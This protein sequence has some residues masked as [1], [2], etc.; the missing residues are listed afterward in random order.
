MRTV[1]R[2]LIADD[3]NTIVQLVR[4][5]LE[6]RG[7]EVIAA[8]DGFEA[9]EKVFF[10]KPDLV[11]LDVVMPKMD[12]YQLCQFF[13]QE[14]GLSM[15]PIV[16]L[17]SKTSSFDRFWGLKAGANDYFEKPFEPYKLVETVEK[18]LT[19]HDGTIIEP[20]KSIFGKKLNVLLEKISS[21]RDDPANLRVR[22][23]DMA[24]M[25]LSRINALMD[26][27]LM[28]LTLIK[29]ISGLISSTGNINK[30]VRDLL[31]KLSLLLDYS[32]AILFL[33]DK[34][35]SQMIIQCK[36]SISEKFLRSC[37][38]LVLDECRTKGIYNSSDNLS[39]KIVEMSEFNVSSHEEEV[40]SKMASP[41]V[42]RGIQIGELFL[43]SKYDMQMTEEKVDMLDLFTSQISLL[44]DNVTMVEKLKAYGDQK[45]Q[46]LSTIYEI[47]RLMSSSFDMINL[48]NMVID[49]V[50]Y[51]MNVK[52][53]SMMLIDEETEEIKVKLARGMNK[54]VVE[55]MRQK[56]NKESISGWV[57]VNK[58]PLLVEDI[59]DDDRFATNMRKS[60]TS[61]SFI[62]VPI[63]SRGVIKGVLNIT[64][65]ESGENFNI[66]DLEM[67]T[68][69]A[70]QIAQAIENAN[71]YKQ[72]AE[73]ERM[74]RELEIARN[75]QMS[76][77]PQESPHIEELDVYGKC[78]PAKE[79]SGDYFDYLGL[80]EEHFSFVIGDV[81]GKGVPAALTV[82]MI[83]SGLRTEVVNNSYPSHLLTKLNSVIIEDIDPDMF[84]TLFF[85]RF[86]RKTRELEY[87]NGGHEFPLLYRAE[88]DELEYIKKSGL[89]V[90]MF[91]NAKYSCHKKMINPGDVILFYT[92]GVVDVLNKD[93][94][95]FG[96]EKFRN[97]FLKYVRQSSKN[98]VEN[99]IKEIMEFKGNESQFDDIT[100]LCFSLKS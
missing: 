79:M 47:G 51:V 95:K 36:S 59:R 60:Y 18:L 24:I 52:K 11:I 68:L 8:S 27:R 28:E 99:I 23:N 67:M 50:I 33:R 45:S 62:C 34:N 98:I 58:K 29:E 72:L 41:L 70:G 66:D 92:D 54:Q 55:T 4:M 26:K 17:T 65:K 74:D 56:V 37:R 93:K 31:A 3:S 39:V 97:L 32:V 76:W 90:G 6:Q 49:N 14:E 9:I 91:H 64:D 7:F 96:M 19:E 88:T 71:L 42:I 53:C 1:K 21:L 82:I 38:G 30:F 80:N 94:E 86:N 12:G 20:T 15:L 84:V 35:K 83:R 43:L 2:I 10:Q 100:L 40:K 57:I 46:R 48:L 16:I 87:A 69:L 25:L 85:G 81:S 78:V 73:K 61:F 5:A 89:L 44:I 63:I 75:I 22:E 77:L 13:R